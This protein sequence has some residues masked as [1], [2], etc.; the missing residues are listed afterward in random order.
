MTSKRNQTNVIEVTVTEGTKHN[1]LPSVT[2]YRG[3]ESLCQIFA[4]S[5]G[6][7][8]NADHIKGIVEEIIEQG[9][10]DISNSKVRQALNK[11]LT[12]NVLKI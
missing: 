5:N 7:T 2:V 10:P 1:A 9:A 8:P 3:G 12:V 6:V 4:D 11:K